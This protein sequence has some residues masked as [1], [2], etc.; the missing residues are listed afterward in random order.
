DVRAA[1]S[2]VEAAAGGRDLARSLRNRDVTV[3]LSYDHYPVNPGFAAGSGAGTGSTYGLFLSLPL[4]ARYY[5]E[6]E[7]QQAEAGYGA[8]LDTLEKARAQARSELAR[9]GSDLHA[10]AERLARY[11]GPLLDEA[12]KA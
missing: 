2:R 5:Y 6:G 10:A 11:D 7:I 4:F 12:T 1:K 3:G 8:A 9:A